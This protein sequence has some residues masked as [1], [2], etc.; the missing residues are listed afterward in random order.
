MGDEVERGVKDVLGFYSLWWM[1]VPITGKNS[2]Y[3]KECLGRQHGVE[4]GLDVNLEVYA[5]I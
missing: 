2:R 4:E 5:S 3:V 1:M